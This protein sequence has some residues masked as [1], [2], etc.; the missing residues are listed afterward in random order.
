MGLST[1]FLNVKIPKTLILAER[2][3]LDKELMIAQ[4]QGKFKLSVLMDVGHSVQEDDFKGTAKL[5]H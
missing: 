4:M 2:E 5:L 3:R 1:S